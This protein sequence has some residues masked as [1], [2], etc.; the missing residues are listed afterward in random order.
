MCIFLA[1]DLLQ[2]IGNMLPNVPVIV[3]HILQEK[4]QALSRESLVR[5]W[6]NEQIFFFQTHYIS[7]GVLLI[8]I[9]QARH[10][11]TH[12]LPLNCRLP[13]FQN[14]QSTASDCYFYIPSLNDYSGSTAKYNLTWLRKGTFAKR[15]CTLKF[16]ARMF[17]KMPH[18]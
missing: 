16:G 10:Q 12:I 7:L 3:H 13:L 6:D 17:K 11:L 18:F 15:R 14:H 5:G 8:S 9:T 1:Y 4:V 2:S